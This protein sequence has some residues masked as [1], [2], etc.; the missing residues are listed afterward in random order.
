M[1]E[2]VTWHL[3][4]GVGGEQGLGEDVVEGKDAQE[5]DHDRLVDR[6]A[7][8]GGAPGGVHALV[9]ADDRDDRPEQGR[10]QDRA[11]ELGHRGVGEQGGE[12][13]AQ[14]GVVGEVGE[15]AAGDPEQERV[16]VEQARDQHQGEEAGHDQVL[17]RVDPEDLEGVELLADLSG[18]E[19]GGDRGPRHPGDHDR[20][21]EGGELADRG[22][23]EEAPEPVEGPEQGGEV[24]RLKPRGAEAEGD[25]R[26]QHRKPAELEGEDELGDELAA[27]G[28][29][30]PDGGGDRLA[31]EDHHV[32]H[33]LEQRLGG[34]ERPI[35]NGSDHLLLRPHAAVGG[36]GNVFHAAARRH[37]QPLPAPESTEPSFGRLAGGMFLRA[38]GESG[39]IA[40][41]QRLRGARASDRYRNG[42]ACPDMGRCRLRRR[43]APGRHRA[44]GQLPGP[45]GEGELPQAAS[46]SSRPATSSS[47]SRTSATRRSPTSR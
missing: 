10:L 7:H 23:D 25:G 41:R 32:P 15:D 24:G 45:G 27:V 38:L 12:E 30:G 28:V 2:C 18:P 8:P 3:E 5:G 34:Q 17:D 22:Q 6:P 43:G 35:G 14:G 9:G 29:G 39:T 40:G 31:G 21:H 19:V 36:R 44:V 11:P 4:L 13:A 20:G 26:D 47:R 46:S 16:D 42:R 1:R 37:P 33:L